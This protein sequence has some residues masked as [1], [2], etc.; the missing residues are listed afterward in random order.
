MK[1]NALCRFM[2]IYSLP[3][4]SEEEEVV[5]STSNK[6]KIDKTG[7]KESPRE[8]LNNP[9]VNSKS[10]HAKNYGFEAAKETHE[11]YP[12]VRMI[13]IFKNVYRYILKMHV[14]LFV[15]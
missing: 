11:F 13:Q 14:C 5:V 3:R 15:Y 12:E 9:P 6:R 2:Y 7:T 4:T 10:S 8:R 1:D